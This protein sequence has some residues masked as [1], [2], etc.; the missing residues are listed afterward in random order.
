MNNNSFNIIQLP[1]KLGQKLNDVM[2][3]A[4]L[5]YHSDDTKNA[6]AV[7]NLNCSQLAKTPSCFKGSLSQYFKTSH[8]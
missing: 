2:V 4:L 7:V 3:V 1:I 5:N 8:F 6:K